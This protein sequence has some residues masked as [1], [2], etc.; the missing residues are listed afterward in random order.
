MQQLL[1]DLSNSAKTID[2]LTR[3]CASL[4][5]AMK[6]PRSQPPSLAAVIGLEATP[7][8]QQKQFDDTDIELEGTSELVDD[9][10][11]EVESE[12]KKALANMKEELTAVK[13]ERDAAR[14]HLRL[15]ELRMAC[16]PSALFRQSPSKDTGDTGSA[17]KALEDECEALRFQ[18]A[19]LNESRAARLEAERELKEEVLLL[20]DSAVQSSQEV[21]FLKRERDDLRHLLQNCSSGVAEEERKQWDELLSSEAARREA[22]R[23]QWRAYLSNRIHKVV[24]LEIENEVLRDTL[25]SLQLGLEETELSPVLNSQRQPEVAG[26]D[27]D[28]SDRMA[29]LITRVQ[30][31]LSKEP[32][33]GMHG[34]VAHPIV[35]RRRQRS[36]ERQLPPTSPRTQYTG[37]AS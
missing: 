32:H 20:R 23:E 5:R 19:S 29:S 8:L 36:C 37:A 33:L 25:T 4:R 34:N 2:A 15:L 7:I 13:R 9:T 30:K 24:Q 21:E 16:R 14:E 26:E 6:A 11:D 28:E 35:P 12:G 18:V 22:I 17:L 10:I 27:F 3:E 31:T 1:R